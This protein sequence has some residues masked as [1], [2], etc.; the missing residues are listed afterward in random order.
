MLIIVVTLNN[1]QVK[2]TTSGH[3][4]VSSFCKSCFPRTYR[5]FECFKISG[6]F[7]GAVLV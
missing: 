7:L 5:S 3:E 1:K 6:D 2:I 4:T